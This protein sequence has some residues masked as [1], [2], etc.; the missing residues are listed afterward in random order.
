MG[1]SRVLKIFKTKVAGVSHMGLRG[2]DIFLKLQNLE[3]VY[4]SELT[5]YL[6]VGSWLAVDIKRGPLVHSTP[7]IHSLMH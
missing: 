5:L 7:H 2:K 6:V 1:W 3:A 4:L